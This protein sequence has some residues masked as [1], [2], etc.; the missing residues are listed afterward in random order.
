MES[1]VKG[2]LK[3]RVTRAGGTL[4]VEGARDYNGI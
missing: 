4:P 3:V 2:Y 1:T